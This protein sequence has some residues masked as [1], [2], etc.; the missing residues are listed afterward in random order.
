MQWILSLVSLL[1][2]L[3]IIRPTDV[4]EEDDGELNIL[5]QPYTHEERVFGVIL[6]IIQAIIL[7]VNLIL[8]KAMGKRVHPLTLIIFILVACIL[9]SPFFMF[10][11]G[12]TKL[13]WTDIYYIILMG[14]A[15]FYS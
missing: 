12:M 13:T 4:F 2:V 14:I 5:G 10:Y 3:M 6:C 8:I 1:G 15:Y 11:N 9:F 7:S